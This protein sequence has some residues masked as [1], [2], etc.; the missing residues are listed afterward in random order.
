M[1][2]FDV[3]MLVIGFLAGSLFVFALGATVRSSEN[4]FGIAAAKDGRILIKTDRSAPY[5]VD[6]ATG[7]AI[8]VVFDKDSRPKLY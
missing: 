3:K 5:L 2:S 4:S 7:K 8:P 6:A 1:K